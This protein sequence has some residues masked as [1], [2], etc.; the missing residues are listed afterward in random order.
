MIADKQGVAAGLYAKLEAE[1]HQYIDDGVAC[2]EL[3]IPSLFPRHPDGSV[4]LL[5][6]YQS[7]GARGV[8][9]I[10]SKMMMALFPPNTPVF[11]LK[12]E[13]EVLAQLGANPNIKTKVETGLAGV[14]RRVTSELESK[15]LHPAAFELFK[16]LIVVGN[17]L[18]YVPDEGAIKSFSLH[19]YVVRRDYSGNPLEVVL[20]E[21]IARVAL[22]IAVQEALAATK[23]TNEKAQE[24][25]TIYTHV[26]RLK[27]RWEA[28]QEVGGQRVDGTYGTYPLGK[29]PWI[30]LRLIKQDG[31]NYGRSYVDEYKG[32]LLSLEGLSQALLEG[33]IA[34]AKILFLVSPNGTTE[35]NDLT[36]AKNG[37]FVDGNAADVQALQLQKYND[38]RVALEQAN[39]ITERL[40]F[41]FLLNS[42]VQRGGERVTAEEIRYV[43]REL[44]DSLGGMYSLLSQELQMPLVSRVMHVLTKAKKLPDF[45]QEDVNPVIITGMEALG[46]GNDLA[47]L[48]LAMSKV[49]V[50]GPEAITSRL[51]VSDFI[52]RVFT[53]CGVD[54]Q[55]LIKSDEQ[56]QAEQ[57][58]AQMQ[59][60]MQQGLPNA[61]NA[62][63][64]ILS[65][66]IENG[67]PEET[68]GQ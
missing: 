51:N 54:T 41:A 42:A 56:F 32:D 67:N 40:S 19:N 4:K 7:V 57:Q 28:Y 49:A 9:N 29:C 8:N 61:I 23:R 60:M 30:P 20:K 6:P 50:L 33:A 52:D 37:A 62:G 17:I 22:P 45:P 66:G 27:D 55:G 36:G 34:A 39:T 31:K 18:V 3:T 35:K 47:K 14:E 10:A 5:T 44:E 21:K 58:Q 26:R 43:A 16:H 68:K 11:R 53:S 59:A 65:Q 24:E 12:I 15:A 64:K 25:V 38:F 63:G 1:R 2:A 48:E 46:R 13:P